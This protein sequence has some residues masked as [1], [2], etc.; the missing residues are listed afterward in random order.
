MRLSATIAVIDKNNI[1]IISKGNL[2]IL[3]MQK[4]MH[5]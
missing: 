1:V 5:K 3:N 4:N 2:K